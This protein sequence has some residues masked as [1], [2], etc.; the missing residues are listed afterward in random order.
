MKKAVRIGEERGELSCRKSS[1]IVV[2]LSKIVV[3]GSRELS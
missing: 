1:S 3:E 2:D